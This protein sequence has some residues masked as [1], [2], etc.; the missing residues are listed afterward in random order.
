MKWNHKFEVLQVK[1]GSKFD[2]PDFRFHDDFLGEGIGIPK[3][4]P[5]RGLF[6]AFKLFNG[7]R[8]EDMDNL[9]V[10]LR[11]LLLEITNSNLRVRD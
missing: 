3:D 11:D 9:L 1:E 5:Q 4:F 7:A 8:L 10:R 6:M 2:D